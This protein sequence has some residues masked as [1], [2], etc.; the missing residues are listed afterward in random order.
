MG[1]YIESI[2]EKCKKL[3]NDSEKLRNGKLQTLVKSVMDG[4]AYEVVS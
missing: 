4:S 2:L 3:K 1:A